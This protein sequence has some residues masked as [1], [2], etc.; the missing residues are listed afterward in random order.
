MARLRK[1]RRLSRKKRK[2]ARKSRRRQRGGGVITVSGG[3]EI[4]TGEITATCSDPSVTVTIGQNSI[5]L[6]G[7]TQP[8]KDI[9]LL[10]PKGQVAGSKIGGSANDT[11]IHI[12]DANSLVYYIIPHSSLFTQIN[13]TGNVVQAKLDST[14]GT[15]FPDGLLLTNITASNF[16]MLLPTKDTFT[17]N[18]LT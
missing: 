13:F 12:Q 9:I 17:I 3:I 8:I 7:L 10:G 14:N 5:T 15:S 4:A 6:S 16:D 1:V 18:L 11:S 2:F